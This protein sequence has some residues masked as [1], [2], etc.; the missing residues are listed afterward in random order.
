M[1][2]KVRAQSWAI[3]V[4]LLGIF[5]LQV[6]FSSKVKSPAWDEPG[7]IASGLAYVQL[8]TLAVNPQH[9]PLL[10]ALSGLSLTLAGVRWPHVP[11]ARELLQGVSRWQWDVGS[12]ILTQNGIDSALLW[13]R[14][15]MMLVGVMGGLMVYIWVRCLAGELAGLG[16]LFLYCLDPTIIAHSYLATLDTGLAAFTLLYLFWLWRYVCAPSTRN[17]VFAGVTLGLLLCTKYSSPAMLPVTAVLLWAG[18]SDGRPWS[19][20]PDDVCPCGSGRKLKNCHTSR[21]YSRF[22]ARTLMVTL[23]SLACIGAIALGVVEVTYRFRPPGVYLAGLNL[24]NADHGPTSLAYMAGRVAPRFT[25]YFA[26]AYLLKEPLAAISLAGVGLVF[27]LRGRDFPWRDRLFLVLPAVTLFL[28]H[29]WKADDLGIRYIIPC[30]PFAHSL[31]GIGLAALLRAPGLVKRC[32]A[33]GLCAWAVVA[34]AGIYPD[35]LSYFNEAACVLDDPGKLGI[36]GGSRC[37]VA[38]LDDSNVDWGE[39]LKQLG[40][41]LDYNA[42]GRTARLAYFGTFPVAA[43]RLP[44]EAID[45]SQLPVQP[46]PGIYSVSANYL[47]RLS[48]VDERGLFFGDLWI[49]R[50]RP[51][52]I[53][54]HCLYVFDIP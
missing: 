24:V 36:D 40:V 17:L 20:A 4:A 48:G 27:L 35:H 43:Y 12:L 8:G 54:G 7:H 37:G 41:W 22:N 44:V 29:V 47:A 6:F 5:F 19:A 18:R 31:G 30:L 34:A 11:E 52:A 39:G 13:A 9:P 33:A 10:K 2:P 46:P 28:I 32:L 38:W 16:A 45:V 53:V 23:R 42:K 15:P 14:L 50:A 49:F 3:A 25:S 51:V 21:K 1:Q 26:V